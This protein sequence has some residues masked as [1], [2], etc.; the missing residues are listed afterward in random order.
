M[1]NIEG[2]SQFSNRNIYIIFVNVFNFYHPNMVTKIYK[3][4]KTGVFDYIF[5]RVSAVIQ[6]LYFSVISFYWLFYSPSNF[7]QFSYFFD[8]LLVEISTVLVCF[9]IAYH[10]LQGIWNMATDYLT[11]RLIGSSAKVLRPLIIGF[12][13]VQ[14]T[15]LIFCSLLL[16]G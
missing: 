15:G 3:L 8:I 11:E 16:L 14:A 4:K 13:W 2:W 5:V 9:S 10:S 6:G 1:G 7:E 12:S